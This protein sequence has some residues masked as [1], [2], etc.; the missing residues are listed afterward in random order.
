[1][2]ATIHDRS[3]LMA[4]DLQD[5]T[6]YLERHGW[7]L[8]ETVAINSSLWTH[9][10]GST[11][12]ELLL[13]AKR[14]TDDYATRISQAL[15]VLQR[16]EDRSQLDI[17]R[18]ITLA[19]VDVIKIRAPEVDP[20]RM[21][22]HLRSGLEILG[23]AMEM[24]AA[25]ASAALSPRRVLPTRR[26]AQVDEYLKWLELGQSE[27]GSYVL[28]ILSRVETMLSEN[29]LPLFELLET[30]FPRKVTRTL[31]KALEATKSAST[32]S[33]SQAGYQSFIDSVPNGIS[34]NLCE[35]I[36]GMLKK[37]PEIES[38]DLRITWAPKVPEI[39]L[40]SSFSFIRSE[41]DVLSEA[42]R[43]LRA[44]SPTEG[45]LITGV[46]INLHREEG[47]TDGIATVACVIDGNIRKLA[48]PLQASDY[49]LA[50]EAHRTKRA[51]LFKADIALVGRQYNAANVQGLRIV[52]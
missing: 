3:A 24:M 36:A 27:K 15:S 52:D 22:T 46:V 41:A 34:A 11:E 4:I 44:E 26:P 32:A 38:I 51:L 35:A 31:S 37:G 28:T 30:P 5:L 43:V 14:S 47:A 49:N 17:L 23:N 50:I 10:E 13:P 9:T 25:A 20:K 45:I 19:G 8:T 16:I 48:V 29:I 42:A 7:R 21:S 2:K 39:E 1:M 40:P 12:S 6:A 18:D 33:V